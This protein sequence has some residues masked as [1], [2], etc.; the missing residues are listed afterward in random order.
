MQNRPRGSRDRDGEE[1]DQLNRED[2]EKSRSQPGG[3]ERMKS[4]HR[5]LS[6]KA[7]T[8]KFV[9]IL[10]HFLLVFLF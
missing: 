2:K 3:L 1:P 5:R 9:F 4:L 10:L 7:K 8:N 6:A